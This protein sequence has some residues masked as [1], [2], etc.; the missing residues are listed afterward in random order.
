MRSVITDIRQAE[1]WV[2]SLSDIALAVEDGLGSNYAEVDVSVLPCPDL[3]NFGCAFSG[4]GGDPILVEIGG[5]P[6]VHNPRYRDEGSLDLRELLE[7]CGRPRGKLLGAGFPSLAATRGKCG[8]LMPC[9]ELPGRNL[10]KLAR[11]GRQGQ[12]IVEDYHSHLHGGLGNL[13][14]CDGLPGDVIR[15]EVRRRTGDEG[16]LSQA[17]RASLQPLVA[18]TPGK[19]IALGGVFAVEQGKVRAHVSPDFDCVPFPYYDQDE[20]R[21]VRPDFLQFYDGM[22]PELMCMSVLW[23]GDPSE[24]ALNLRPTGEH[25]HF[26]S[27]RGRNEAG[28][29]HYDVT[30]ETIHYV[31]CFHP[32]GRIVRVADIYAILG[33][34]PD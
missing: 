6:L 18:D 9:M 3:R 25:T 21:V 22:G 15:V 13:Y 23:T 17:I 20:E 10:S 14:V 26:F 1:F 32:A 4:L 12:C 34:R 28:H 30:P 11:V 2:P 7:A 16:S 5:E 29:Y 19:E 8:E 31:G 24:G 27:T 33:K